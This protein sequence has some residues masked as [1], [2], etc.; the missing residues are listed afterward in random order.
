MKNKSAFTILELII[1]MA[2]MLFLVT[3]IVYAY[4]ACF[5]AFNAGQDRTTVRTKLLQAMDL[6]T[7]ELYNAQ[8]ITECSTTS[9]CS[10]TSSPCVT[11][12]PDLVNNYTYALS[13]SNLVRKDDQSGLSVVKAT[14]IQTPNGGTIP[15]IFTCSNSLV[16]I[17]MTAVQN[18]ERVRL[19]SNVSPRNMPIGLVGWWRFDDVYPTVTGSCSTVVDSSGNGNTGTCVS[20]P[21]WAAGQISTVVGG[22]SFNGT[23]QFVNT[24]FTTQPAPCTVAAWV[25]PVS[26]SL[27][28]IEYSSVVDDGVY[29]VRAEQYSNQPV[30]FTHYGVNDYI[31]SPSYALTPN[32]W[33]HLVFVQ[34]SGTSTLFANGMQQGTINQTFSCPAAYIGREKN[35]AQTYYGSMA[36]VR[37]Y[38]RALSASEISQL[39]NTGLGN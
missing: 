38:N 24:A 34:I 32:V 4:L 18:A 8:S 20:G 7:R 31:Y 37:I 9:N 21:T 12:S 2:M 22:L 35:Y 15:K 29:S 1:S 17:D 19:Q 5:R 3:G 25:K 26:V 39:Y 33:T 23:N 28:T 10:S 11:F 14:G 30:G 36:D 13:G 16:A 6:M 27:P